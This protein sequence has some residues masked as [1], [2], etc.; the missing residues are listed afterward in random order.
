LLREQFGLT[1]K[2]HESLQQEVQ[3]EIYLQAITDVWQ[4]GV[5]TPQDSE[6]LEQLRDQFNISAEE[7]LRLEK[8][9]RREILKQKA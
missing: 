8:Q 6:L 5:I 9:I 4:D 3:I 2:E 1:Q 7:H